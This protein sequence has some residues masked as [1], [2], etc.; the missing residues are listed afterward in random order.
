[1]K[2]FISFIFIL[3]LLLSLTHAYTYAAEISLSLDRDE[4]SIDDQATL[5]LSVSGNNDISS[6]PEILNTQNFNIDSAGTSSQISIINGTSSVKK[7]FNYVL[8]PR[9]VGTFTIGPAK[10]NLGGKVI[11][12]NQV[13]LTV[14]KSGSGNANSNQQIDPDQQQDPNQNQDSN[15]AIQNNKNEQRNIFIDTTVNNSNPYLNQSIVYTFRLFSRVQASN[16]GLSLPDFK[17]FRKE[18]IG[19]PSHPKQYEANVNG[20]RYLVSELRMALFPT[21]AGT[22]IIPAATITADVLV[23]DPRALRRSMLGQFFGNGIFGGG[24]AQMKKIQLKSK[25]L[26][27]N[28]RPLP[29]NNKPNN[30]SGL[31]GEF[32][33]EGNIGKTN[34]KVGESTTLTLRVSGAGNIKEINLDN[35][36]P[37]EGFKSYDD[38]PIFEN[39]AKIFKKALVPTREG[40]LT[41]P[42]IVLSY[43]NPKTGS[44]QTSQTQAIQLNVLAGDPT[45][46]QEKYLSSENQKNSNNPNNAN[47]N[48]NNP[49]NKKEIQILGQDLMP[50][51]RGGALEKSDELTFLEKF[52]IASIFLISP[53]LYV[54]AL[55]RKR[56]L[57][58]IDQDSGLLLREN[59][60]KSF[61]S[62]IT[63]INLS[64]PD[65]F[66]QISNI[67]REYLSN[68]LKLQS[69]GITHMDIERI[70]AAYTPATTTTTAT[71]PAQIVSDIKKFLE[72]CESMQYGGLSDIYN[73]LNKKKELKSHL[74]TLVKNLEKVLK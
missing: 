74:E 71:V 15:S 25:N 5:E 45:D 57:D 24:L 36:P 60:Y 73:N 61:K 56:R 17:G 40:S 38:K 31:V 43:F 62:Q 72:L 2:T 63:K 16:V 50:I 66:A 58:L 9:K 35:L 14:S 30:F 42:P 53:I 27:I 12:T 3:T 54:L 41:I 23:Q 64:E 70:F 6:E 44:Y 1:M 21:S 8:T 49:D 18:E 13:K 52:F 48:P 29:E 11:I 32:R 20:M 7:I 65:F 47:N 37:F 69:K 33:I 34:L 22:V 39:G 10:V 55:I 46:N 59:A 26:K 67:L 19:D 51:V 4:I 68:K 28:V